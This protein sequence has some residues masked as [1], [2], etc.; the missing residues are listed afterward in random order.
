MLGQWLGAAVE[1]NDENDPPTMESPQPVAVPG[2]PA[3]LSGADAVAY[4]TDFSDP[5]SDG[6]TRATLELAG[7]Y[8]RA[9]IWLNGT[10]LGSHESY[11][12]PWRTTFDPEPEN[13]LVVECRRPADAF[14]GIYETDL[15]PAEHRVPGIWWGASVEPHGP[16]TITDLSVTPELEGDGGAIHAAITVDA[17]EPV[18]D[19][20]TLSIRPKGFRGGG[21]MERARVEAAA[22]ERVVVDRRIEVREPRLW[23]PRGFGSQH[24]YAVHAKLGEQEE[25]ATTGFSTISYGDD[26]LVVNGRP[27]PARG[28]NVLPGAEAEETVE[29]AI[30]ANANL[31]RTHAHVPSSAFYDVCDEAGLLVWQDVPLTGPVEYDPKRGIDVCAALVERCESRPSVAAYGVHDDPRSPFETPLG[32]G[33]LARMRLRWRAWRTAFDRTAADTLADGIETDR[34]VF[35]VMGSPGTE[36]DAS[37]LYPGWEYGTAEDIEWLT[38]R[39]PGLGDVVT[40]FGAGSLT[41]NGE[42]APGTHPAFDRLDDRPVETQHEQ[43]RILKHVAERLRLEHVDVLA[44]FTLQDV[45]PGGGMGVVDANGIEK[46]SF[47]P[48][49]AAYEPVQ[50]VVTDPLTP[51]AVGVTV[52]NDTHERVSGTVDWESGTRSG[53]VDVDAEPLSRVSVGGARVDD[54]A[55]ELV[56][57]LSTDGQTVRNSY[58]LP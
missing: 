50:A 40:E 6:D 29:R 12:T 51:G 36:P 8:G 25:I 44:A 7:L 52:I 24:R 4:R 17:A 53:V 46:R 42:G 38:Q 21:A 20:V 54:D 23:W 22:G 26:G 16:V 15:L 1:P 10:F 32:S 41:E 43:G 5:C 28:F 48:I 11:F 27:I 13:E 2:R 3:A 37:H 57:E 39:Y 18:D 45:R 33:R 49:A 9:R 47:D 14:G 56:L 30:D 34:P 55:E 19:R 58:R 31:L 35:P